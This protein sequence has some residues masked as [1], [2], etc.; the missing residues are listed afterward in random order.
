MGVENI[1]SVILRSPDNLIKTW[2][3]YM[4]K[5][6]SH[7]A[8]LLL[9]GVSAIAVVLFMVK[10]YRN[11]GGD[12]LNELFVFLLKLAFIGVLVNSFSLVNDLFLMPL[13]NTSESI[14]SKLASGAF[15]LP[16][17]DLATGMQSIFSRVFTMSND[18]YAQG[19]VF[20]I[21]SYFAGFMLLISVCGMMLY[22]VSEIV[23]AKLFFGIMAVFLPL[24]CLFSLFE[25][26]RGFFDRYIGFVISMFLVI[27]MVPAACVFA[28]A[29]IGYA[30]PHS[31]NGLSFEDAM[32]A[33][34]AGGVGWLCIKQAAGV[35]KHMGGAFCAGSALN[36]NMAAAS[37]TLMASKFATTS[38]LKDRPLAAAGTKK[39]GGLMAPLAKRL[40]KSISGKF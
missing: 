36:Q 28:M 39:L 20:S 24:F 13:I 26:M 10:R 1:V 3:E 33:V 25:S 7:E 22:A 32:A 16:G 40:G 2:V 35:A 8:L 29:L 4:Y 12:H 21:T 31:T 23:V 6:V 27:V 5:I 11:P 34:F 14:A 9:S 37:G 17:A 38:R 30:L 18:L 15:G 19:G